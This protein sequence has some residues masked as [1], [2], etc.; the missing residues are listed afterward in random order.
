MK[1]GFDYSRTFFKRYYRP[2]NTTLVVTGDVDPAAMLVLAK[3]SY[4]GW[5]GKAERPD[6]AEFTE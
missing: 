2:D 4:G 1:D 6:L 3:K 5:G